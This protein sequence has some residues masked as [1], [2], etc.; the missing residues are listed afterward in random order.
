MKASAHGS[1]FITGEYLILD[2]APALVSAVDRSAQAELVKSTSGYSVD[3]L[4]GEPDIQLP[5]AVCRVLGKSP[6]VLRRVKTSIVGFGSA[7]K[8]YG[9][10]SSAASCAALVRLLAP[11]LDES[12]LLEKAGRAHRLFQ[13][14]KGSN[15]DVQLAVLGGTCIVHTQ[16]FSNIAHY[17]HVEM[18]EGLRCDVVWMEASA[19]TVSFISKFEASR[20]TEGFEKIYRRLW[21]NNDAV[22]DAFKNGKVADFLDTL[23]LQDDLL[24]HL[25]TLIQAPICVE[26]HHELKKACGDDFVAKVSGSGGGDVSLVFGRSNADWASL[27]SRLPDGVQR[28]EILIDAKNHVK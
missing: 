10:S 28:L 7:E 6:D 20:S 26:A 23:A 3:G 13:K 12:E 19:K 1:V 9:L 25:G 17:E 15:A 16:D 14:G 5:L 22:L 27:Q 4:E 8:K 24:D 11:N 18:P 2:G 21:D